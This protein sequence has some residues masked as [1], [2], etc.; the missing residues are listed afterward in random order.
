MGRRILLVEDDESLRRGIGLKLEREGYQVQSAGTIAEADSWCAKEEADL[1]ICDVMLPDG[2]GL[3]F[4]RALRRRSQTLFLF[5][6]AMD[7]ELDIVN[8]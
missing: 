1:V 5:L 4:C 3:E 2:S 7:S 8:G 6:T